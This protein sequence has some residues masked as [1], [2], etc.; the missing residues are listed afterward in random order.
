MDST[1]TPQLQGVVIITLPPPDNPSKG[2]TI[3]SIFTLSNPNTPSPLSTP[4][5]QT[6]QHHQTFS[7]KSFFNTPRKALGLLSFSLLAILLF[8]SFSSSNTLYELRNSNNEDDDQKIDSFFLNS[9]PKMSVS[10]KVGKDVEFKLG[11]VVQR[12]GGEWDDVE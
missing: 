2:K 4:Q 8:T 9:D 7:F 12:C 5:Q 10:E 1:S 11:R 3:T 6:P